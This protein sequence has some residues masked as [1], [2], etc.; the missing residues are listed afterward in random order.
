M[1]NCDESRE[2]LDAGSSRT[3]CEELRVHAVRKATSRRCRHAGGTQ[4]RLRS[5]RGLLRCPRHVSR[6]EAWPARGGGRRQGTCGLDL[7]GLTRR[8]L[9]DRSCGCIHPGACVVSQMKGPSKQ[10]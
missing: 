9:T 3:C 6:R 5:G 10:V 7:S 4:G 8:G 1:A 2:K